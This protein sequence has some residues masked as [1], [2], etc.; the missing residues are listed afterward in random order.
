MKKLNF[1]LN[2]IRFILHFAPL[3]RHFFRYLRI[4]F[5]HFSS[6]W[7]FT[8][9]HKLTKLYV[10][11]A[12]RSPDN[13][14]E[15]EFLFYYFEWR[16][17]KF[18]KFYE[19][20]K[21]EPQEADAVATSIIIQLARLMVTKQLY[22]NQN[23]TIN[24]VSRELATNRTYVSKEINHSYKSGFRGY[25]NHHRLEKAK[26]IIQSAQSNDI[27]LMAVSEQVGFRNY[28]TFNTAFKKKYGITPGEW[29]LKG[30][31]GER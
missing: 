31:Q 18:A 14:L 29:K 5:L 26:E 6:E 4:I 25:V 30:V 7:L 22:M 2:R 13:S 17:R 15:A 19:S 12:Y 20:C 11:F 27:N 3:L 16:S 28:G 1:Y 21:G 24:D 8:I 10:R 9:A 23:L